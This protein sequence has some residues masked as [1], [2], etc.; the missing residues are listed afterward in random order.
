MIILLK[1][2]TRQGDPLGG[3]LFVMVY[4][5]ILH[6]IV[7]TH[8]TCGFPSL[9]DDTHIIG[10][11]SNVVLVFFMILRGIFN[12]GVFSVVNKACS[13]VSTGVGPLYITSS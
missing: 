12:I 6:P 9:A 10:L 7:A 1:L 11:A 3:V 5:H 13:L 8:P 4:L 2:G